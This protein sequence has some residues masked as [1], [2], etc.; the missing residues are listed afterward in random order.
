MATGPTRHAQ[1][2]RD[3][4]AVDV[5]V[6]Q[7]DLVAP[8]GQ[9]HGQVHRHRRL[10]HAALARRD[11]DHPG[12]RSRGHEPVGPALPR[13]RADAGGPPGPV[14]VGRGRPCAGATGRR[15]RLRGRAPD[16]DGARPLVVGHGDSS[17]FTSPTPGTAPHAC[18]PPGRRARRRP[19]H[20]S[21]GSGHDDRGLA[22]SPTA[23]DRTM[24]SSPRPRRR[25]G[26]S[27]AA[28]AARTSASVGATIA[29]LGTGSGGATRDFAAPNQV[30][31]WCAIGARPRRERP[32]RPPVLG[33]GGRRHLGLRR[34]DPPRDLPLRAVAPRGDGVGGGRPRSRCTRTWPAT[35]STGWPPAGTSR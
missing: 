8:G 32:R 4:E 33:R 20:R 28:T 27:T 19:G 21:T 35:I 26:S 3:R 1:H 15:A 11:A 24:P 18:A 10:P 34:P 6:E 2:L 14:R 25:S 5:G 23:T 29:S 13:A 22:T 9:G 7:P 12:A 30:D 31:Y 17:T 16:G